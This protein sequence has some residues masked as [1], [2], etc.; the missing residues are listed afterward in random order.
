MRDDVQRLKRAKRNLENVGTSAGDD[1]AL[2]R[3]KGE[4]EVAGCQEWQ[5]A[6]DFALDDSE[7]SFLL[8]FLADDGGDLPCEIHISA[9]CKSLDD[10]LQGAENE[11]R[12]GCGECD[13][14]VEVVDGE[15]VSAGLHG[16]HAEV[17]QGVV[18]AD[19]V[20]FFLLNKKSRSV[21]ENIYHDSQNLLQE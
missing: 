17:A 1:E 4:V 9:Q 2:D 19:C 8:A 3:S 10:V 21:T 5:L 13:G 18:S 6:G 14:A 16:F 7:P 11:V 20:E 15:L 12:E